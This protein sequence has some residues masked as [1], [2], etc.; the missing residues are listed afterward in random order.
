MLASSTEAK[1]SS[2]IQCPPPLHRSSAGQA[3]NAACGWRSGARS[4]HSG[5]GRGRDLVS[6]LFF[7]TTYCPHVNVTQNPV[8]VRA[9]AE[10]ARVHRSLRLT[11]SQ[12]RA[13]S[14]DIGP[15]SAASFSTRFTSSASS[16][17]SSLRAR[18]FKNPVQSG[19]IRIFASVLRTVLCRK[20]QRSEAR[21]GRQERTGGTNCFQRAISRS[22]WWCHFQEQQEIQRLIQSPQPAAASLLAH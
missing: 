11:L 6:R 20:Q 4:G 13:S 1:H 8:P 14:C 16:S 17:A 7:S 10:G 5:A 9:L 21:S 19:R 12:R 3:R 2:P 18:D 22:V 15:S